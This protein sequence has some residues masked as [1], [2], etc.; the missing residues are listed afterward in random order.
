MN[1]FRCKFSPI[2]AIFL[3]LV[4]ASSCAYVSERVD[5]IREKPA[6]PQPA[7]QPTPASVHLLFG[8]PSNATADLSNRDNYLLIKGIAAYSY[9]NSRG[10]ANWASWRTTSSDLGESIPRPNF[11]PDEYLPEGFTRITPVDYIGSGYDRGHLV[12]SADRFGDS[13]ANLETFA[14]TNIV[15]QSAELNQFPWEK[16]ESYSRR[17][18]RRGYDL[19]TV[20]GCYGNKGRLRRKVTV[21]TN[22]WKTVVVLRGGET[23]ADVDAT[24]RVIAVDMPNTLGIKGNWWETYRTTVRDIEAKTGYDFLSALPPQLQDILETRIDY[25]K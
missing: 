12:P 21:P 3:A 5:S 1:R 23:L 7:P 13:S 19:Y 18:V 10:T 14:M 25:G 20:A 22:C 15:P 11:F 4:F 17:L 8:N 2:F 6:V 16:L 9:N 24:T